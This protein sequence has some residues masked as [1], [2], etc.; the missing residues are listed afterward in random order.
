MR[1]VFLWGYLKESPVQ[2]VKAPPG[3]AGREKYALD[4][5]QAI[6]FIKACYA[7][8]DDLI[9]ALAIATGRRPK[10]L[11]GLQQQRLKL[12][13]QEVEGRTIARGLV[14]VRKIAVK[15]RHNG[16]WVLLEPKTPK[17][18]RDIPFPAQLYYD[19]MDYSDE[20]K[21]R[22]S[23]MGLR[24]NHLDLV[25]PERDGNPIN[26][27]KL[28]KGRLR[29]VLKRASLPLHFTP[30]SLRYSYATLQLLSGERDKVIS[31][32]MGH[33]DVHFTQRVYQ[34]VLPVM[35][36]AASDCMER[37]LFEGVRTT[38]AQSVSERVM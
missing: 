22:R 19:L 27:V 9:F 25:F 2:S 1:D 33:T 15:L 37:L 5:D 21:R 23:L 4:L 38:L 13:T 35:R 8:P 30:Y 31:E 14:E 10:E 28:C 20:I 3:S 12:V 29:R 32:L 7:E 6:K 24:W 36:E 18:V 26:Q 11:I 34:Q 17:S 16:E